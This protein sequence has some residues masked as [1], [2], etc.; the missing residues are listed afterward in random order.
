MD[1]KD[2]L[3]RDHVPTATRPLLGMTI[4]VVEDSR[5]AS[6]AVRLMCIRSGARI[7]RADCLASARRHLQVYRPTVLI[8]DVGLPDGSGL[9]LIREMDG[10]TPRVDVLIATS[11]DE[12]WEA[13]AI[14]A[15]ADGFLAKPVRKMAAFQAEILRHVPEERRPSG[16]R[17]VDPDEVSP[18]AVAYRD[19]MAAVAD[20][21]GKPADSATVGYVTQFLSGV[22]RAARDDVL[23]DAVDALRADQAQGASV[24]AG[25]QRVAGLVQDRIGMRVSI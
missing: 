11:G 2:Y 25:I 1:D 12:D 24:D 18:D 7:R 16:P 19:D 10:A 22:A 9:D 15:G 21:L 17:V 13:A 8:V 5:Y 14:D 6:E 20:T 3:P 23:L 4:L